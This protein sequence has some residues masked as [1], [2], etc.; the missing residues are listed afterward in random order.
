MQNPERSALRIAVFYILAAS[1]WIILSD[2]IVFLLPQD[3]AITATMQTFKGLFFVAITGLGLYLERCYSGKTLFGASQRFER[4]VENIPDV[5]AIYDTDLRIQYIN[6]AAHRLT[7]RPGSDFT[8]KR[9]EEFLPLAVVETY[10]PTLQ[11]ALSTGKVCS[12][13]ADLKMPD[14][15]TFYYQYI[16]VPLLDNEG[17]VQE[18]LSIK[19]DETE[20]MRSDEQSRYHALLQD[21]ISDAVIGTDMEFRIQAWN[22]AAEEIY[23]WTAEE[24]VG[25]RLDEVLRP[26]F[27]DDTQAGAADR[28]LESGFW[29]GETL[30]HDKSGKQIW[31][32]GSFNYVYDYKGQRVGAV[33]V[34]KDVTKRKEA[35]EALKRRAR[36]LSVLHEIDRVI[37]AVQSVDSILHTVLGFIRELIPCERSSVVLLDHKRQELEVFAVDHDGKTAVLSTQHMPLEPQNI[38]AW[39]QGEPSLVDDLSQLP[40]QNVVQQTLFQEG[41]RTVL[42]L[43]LIAHDGLIGTLE[44]ADTQTHRFSA[45]DVEIAQALAVQVSVSIENA[46][47][48]ARLERQVTELDTIHQVSQRLQQVLTPEPLANEI[49]TILEEVLDYEYGSVLLIEEENKL[50]PF[51]L[52]LPGETSTKALDFAHLKARDLQVGKGIVGWVVQHGESVCLGNV[53]EDSRYDPRKNGIRSELCVP[54]QVGKHVIGA[55]NMETSKPNA[56]TAADQRLLETMAAQMAIAIQN[57]QLLA[58]E[59]DSQEQL[60]QLAHYLH[61]ALEAE[62]THIAREIHD[63]FGQM[64]TA[65]KMDTIW[66]QKRLPA[67]RTELDAK[68][69]EMAAL[70]DQAVQSVRDLAS[71]LRPGLLDDLGL[72]AAVEWYTQQFRKRTGVIC[73]IELDSE[74]EYIMLNSAASTAVFRIFQEALTNVARHAEATRVTI[75]LDQTTEGFFMTVRDNGRGV[76]HEELHS[77]RS[78]GIIGMRERARTFGGTLDIQ[79]APGKGTS[80]TLKLPSTQMEGNR[81]D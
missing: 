10:L 9:D 52:T 67:N 58:R 2:R 30:Q 72:V 78:L 39:A 77:Q 21:N 33:S 62:R 36:Q 61:E 37:L 70:I 16:C 24:V 40:Q 6:R 79:T 80:L 63:E 51:A 29:R 65:L 38:Q 81:D 73:E 48:V 22:K 14:G 7:N 68:T 1:L 11:E 60:R 20:R 28:F 35:E 34:N 32:L 53:Q 27:E 5:I 3:A 15:K 19:R 56:Y 47:L 54:L 41:I 13:A 50:V 49:I 18:I 17:Q 26:G 42:N 59:R 64:L 12:I 45:E 31:V 71:E 43:P 55:I 66:L 75:S 76:T 44:L 46:R 23:G 74:S 69:V 4:V 57:S 25:R 8:G